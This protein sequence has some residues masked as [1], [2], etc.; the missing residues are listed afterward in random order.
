MAQLLH[1]MPKGQEGKNNPTT[2]GN[3]GHDCLCYIDTLGCLIKIL[4]VTTF[5][6][7]QNGLLTHI[8]VILIPEFG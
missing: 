6:T 2:K 4:H 5:L 8:L 7:S 1:V 3:L